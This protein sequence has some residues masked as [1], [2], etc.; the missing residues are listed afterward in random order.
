MLEE[1][2]L[3]LRIFDE[4]VDDLLAFLD[5]QVLQLLV[6]Q[7]FLIH[8]LARLGLLLLPGPSHHLDVGANDMVL[9]LRL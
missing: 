7:Q 1:L 6:T 5:Q 4:R 3:K 2:E 8:G 9:N